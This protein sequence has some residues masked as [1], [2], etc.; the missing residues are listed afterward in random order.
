MSEVFDFYRARNTILEILE[1]R[2]YPIDTTIKDV[3]FEEFNIYY[4]KRQINF[5]VDKQDEDKNRM[6]VLFY[7]DSKTFGKKEYNTLMDSID[8]T[9]PSYSIMIVLKDKLNTIMKRELDGEL[10]HYVQFFF[11][12]ELQFNITKHPIVPKHTILSE[13][14]KQEILKRFEA[15]KE[16][17]PIIS[18]NDPVTRYY[19]GKVGDMFE[20]I[21]R[22]NIGLTYFYRV[23]K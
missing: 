15:K 8:T 9:L 2:K 16:N 1:D 10:F 5:H 13:E 19:G 3:S 21:R 4:E 22:T 14:Q 11:L 17:M 7:T 6:Y 18:K 20:I 23:V 12:Y